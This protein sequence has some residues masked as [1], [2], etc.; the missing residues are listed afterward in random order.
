M[1][2]QAVDQVVF[3]GYILKTGEVLAGL[4]A[5]ITASLALTAVF[6]NHYLA[7]SR[8]K[9]E[10]QS[11]EKRNELDANRR[12]DEYQIK[13]YLIQMERV[14]GHVLE[15]RFLV[16]KIR[17]GVENI[18]NSDSLRIFI[19]YTSEYEQRLE[20]IDQKIKVISNVYLSEYFLEMMFLATFQL[21]FGTANA[22]FP[23]LLI[24]ELYTTFDEQQDDLKESVSSLLKHINE[25]EQDI[26]EFERCLVKLIENKQEKNA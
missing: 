22:N 7:V 8:L 26:Y 2:V 13:Q 9:K 19:S 3:F 15:L 5:V 10:L 6:I 24:D 1:E 25:C 20:L 14:F 16:R 23:L 12:E 18:E 17:E 11:Q 4:S 21:E